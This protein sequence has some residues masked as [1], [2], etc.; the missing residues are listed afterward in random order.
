MVGVKS[1]PALAS[2]G[3][4]RASGQVVSC[5]YCG[6]NSYDESGRCTGCNNPVLN[7]PRWALHGRD[8]R[9]LTR[10]RLVTGGVVVA[11]LAFILWLNYPFLPDYRILLFNRP[12]TSITSNSTTGQWSMVGGDIAQ[13]KIARTAGAPVRMPQGK[14][15]WSV[16]TGDATRSGPVVSNGTVYLGGHFKI[17]AFD[18]ATGTPAWEQPATGPIQASL[19]ATG[20]RVYVGLLDHRILALD[21]ASGEIAWEFKAGD[22]ITAA[23]VVE[24]GILYFGSWDGRQY[25][26]DAATGELIWTYEASESIGSHGPIHEGVMAVGDRNG[27][28]HLLNPRTGQNRLVYRTPKSA[29]AAPVIAHDQVFFSAGGRLYA[30]DANEKE[31][32]GQYHFKRVWAQLWL[33]K[34]PGVPRPAGQQGGRWRFSPDGAESSIVASPAAANTSLYVGD[35]QGRLFAIEPVSGIE[36]WRFQA[37]GG[38]YAS[39]IV[40]GGTV[41]IA[42]QEGNV[43]AVNGASGELEWELPLDSPVNEPLA[44]S[45][46][47]LYLRSA[48]GDLHAIE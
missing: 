6:D 7:L 14:V 37:E 36:Q 3:P 44:F 24:E 40:V 8:R 23:P 29:Y 26:L 10:R 39:P 18:A 47:L 25:A 1:L 42:S 13:R 43:Y 2:D 5:P 12:T 21:P 27:R 4:A 22:F 16:A 9:L 45:E 46:G 41:Y 38:I 33:W 19:A 17:M 35:L 20:D 11:V 30:I 34:V 31:I 28:M 48:D 32:P 15:K